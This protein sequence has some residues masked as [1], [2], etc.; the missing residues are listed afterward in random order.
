MP[1]TVEPSSST[2]PVTRRSATRGAGLLLA[3]VLLIALNLRIGITSLGALLDGLDGTGL[4]AGAKS[5]LTSLPVLC[6]AVVGATGMTLAR[7]VGAHRGLAVGLV[8]LVAGLVARVTAGST[9][10]LVGTL[11]ACAGIALANVLL[12]AVVKEHFPERIGQ[13]TGAYSAVLSLGAAVGA[14][15][16]VP[17]ADA[18][19]GWRAGLGIWAG[20]ALLAALVWAPHCLDRDRRNAEAPR[21]SLWRSPVAWAV[22]VV[23]ATQSLFAY[24]VMSWLPS[25]YADA[26]FDHGTSGVLLAV[27]ILIGVPVYF[28]VPTIATRSR[29]QGHLV[30]GLTAITAIGFVGLWWAPAGGALLWAALIGAGGAVFPVSLTLFAL[31]TATAEDTAALSAMAQSVGYLFAAAGPFLVGVLHEHSGSWSVPFALLLAVAAVQLVAGYA[32]GRPVLV[33]G[34][35]SGDR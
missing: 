27:S 31:R 24:V 34:E 35:R 5:F 20:L 25:I 32:A 17:V 29:S 8:L 23:F 1:V 19:G 16:T 9:V 4:S 15:V 6:F 7:R 13:V 2:P 22:T 10:L 26:G 18:A 33:G 11:V 14:A 28:V 12:P 21:T 30:A 3:A